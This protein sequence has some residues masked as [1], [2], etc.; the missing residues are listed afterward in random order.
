[1]PAFD[2]QIDHGAL[3]SNSDCDISAEIGIL[4]NTL[5]VSATREKK[6]F[7]GAAGCTEG[8]R[9]LDP[10]LTF[11]FDGYMA[12]VVLADEDDD[13]SN[14]HPGTA[15]ASIANYTGAI[16]GFDPSDGVLVLEDPSRQLSNEDLCKAT[17][18][19]VQ[20]PFVA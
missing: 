11:D 15:V 7:K 16:Y 2:C 1:M 6:V 9:Y 4:V 17:A 12:P 10:L 14:M 19:I 20:Y 5:N 8:L 18:K 3:A 13:L